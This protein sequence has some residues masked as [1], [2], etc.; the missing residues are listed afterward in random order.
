MPNMVKVTLRWDGSP[1]SPGYSNFYGRSTGAD[2]QVV[3]DALGEALRTFSI[4]LASL[5]HDSMSLV[6]LPAWQQ[7]DD[8][9]GNVL[10]DGNLTTPPT[11]VVGT[12]GASGA[13]N[14]GL[15]VNWGTDVFIAGRRLKGRTYVVPAPGAFETNGTLTA[16][17]I[18]SVGD[19]ARAFAVTGTVP[20]VV[21]HRPVLGAGGSSFAITT[22]QITDR[23]AILRSRSV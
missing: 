23:P 9:S 20:V 21:W 6:V 7:L 15:A 1:G 11:A 22:V 8:V 5:V 13:G 10:A 18:S 17:A 19:A 4:T 12:S 2:E 16:G 14:A 3:A